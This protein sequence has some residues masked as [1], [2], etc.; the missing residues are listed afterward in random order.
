VF[1]DKDFTLSPHESGRIVGPVADL[2]LLEKWIE[3]CEDVHGADCAPI[4][5][6]IRPP[7]SQSGLKMLRVN[8]RLVSKSAAYQR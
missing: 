8:V 5:E 4:T 1:L 7:Q 2:K 6:V 3:L